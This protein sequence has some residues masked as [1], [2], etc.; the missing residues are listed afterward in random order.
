MLPSTLRNME[1]LNPPQLVRD[2]GSADDAIRKKAAFRLQSLIGDPSF[3]DQFIVEGGLK[4]LQFLVKNAG[5]NTLAYTLA[6]FSTILE[7]DQGWEHVDQEVITRVCTLSS[8]SIALAD[9]HSDSSSNSSS[10]NLL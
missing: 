7:L 3:A 10:R 9:L 8:M 4:S 2:L 1:D 5:G 6:S